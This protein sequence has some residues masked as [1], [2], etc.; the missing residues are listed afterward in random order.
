MKR[1]RKISIKLDKDLVISLRLL[2]E[3]VRLVV[4]SICKAFGVTVQ[5]V[6]V[7]PSQRKGFHVYI[8]VAPLIHAE[9]AWRLQFDLGDDGRRCS[10]NRARL[11]AGFSEWNKLFESVRPRMTTI[12]LRSR[13]MLD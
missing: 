2:G 9:L 8:D 12:Y 10:L 1:L 11:R 4:I 3:W 7:C 5:S 13:S 6:T